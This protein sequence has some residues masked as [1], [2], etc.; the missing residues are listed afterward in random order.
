L[1]HPIHLLIFIQKN[2]QFPV[3]TLSEHVVN[4]YSTVSVAAAIY[5]SEI[6]TMKRSLL[7]HPEDFSILVAVYD[8]QFSNSL[9]TKV[10]IFFIEKTTQFF[11]KSLSA[12]V[13]NI[14]HNVL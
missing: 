2:S 6:Y 7:C 13:V 10:T 1:Y 11:V 8:L 5:I 3:A 12:Q 9:D 4:I 14:L